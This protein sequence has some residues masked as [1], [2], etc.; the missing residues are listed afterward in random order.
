M[1]QSQEKER[2]ATR[3]CPRKAPPADTLSSPCSTSRLTPQSDATH[4]RH[5]AAPQ[6]SGHNTGWDVSD[7]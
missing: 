2:K 4:D 1:V 3:P 5:L 7:G 6:I